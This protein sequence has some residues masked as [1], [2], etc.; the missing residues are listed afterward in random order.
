MKTMYLIRNIIFCLAAVSLLLPGQSLFGDAKKPDKKARVAKDKPKDD[1]QKPDDKDKKKEEKKDIKKDEKV[2]KPAE[3]KKEIEEA[4]DAIK[5]LEKAMKKEDDAA[6]KENVEKEGEELIEI[7]EDEFDK[8]V[9]QLSSKYYDERKL[10]RDKIKEWGKSAIPYVEPLLKSDSALVRYAAVDIMQKISNGLY[11][12]RFIEMLDDKSIRVKGAAIWALIS[13]E[14]GKDFYTKI[15][16]RLMQIVENK[17]PY[18]EEIL[19]YL[20]VRGHNIGQRKSLLYMSVNMLF[21]TRNWDASSYLAEYIASFGDIAIPLLIERLKNA[22]IRNHVI[23]DR[24]MSALSSIGPSITPYLVELLET[25]DPEMQQYIIRTLGQC[26][27]SESV[28]ILLKM[29][30]DSK[31]QYVVQTILNNISN[32]AFNLSSSRQGSEFII[33]KTLLKELLSRDKQLEEYTYQRVA[34]QYASICMEEKKY[35]EAIA[36]WRKMLNN[37]SSEDYQRNEI[38]RLIINAYR[39]SGKIDAYMKEIDREINDIDQQL[40]KL[41]LD[42]IKSAH[43]LGYKNLVEL[44]YKKIQLL[45][46]KYYTEEAD[47]ILGKKPEE[48]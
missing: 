45:N 12:D 21:K 46:N 17:E 9:A 7:D 38:T 29:L 30:R 40:A 19:Y 13:A 28:P 44:Y 24:I 36:I 43:K 6:E 48:K 22:D 20:L 37:Y 39:T 47:K 5:R 11:T 33:A 27:G 41:Y 23:N 31:N 3:D 2:A 8:A 10:A 25:A 26:G 15:L 42:A 1:K 18:S 35:D 14:P 4:R 32:I 16:P 34:T